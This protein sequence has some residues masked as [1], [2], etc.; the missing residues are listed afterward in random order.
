MRRRLILSHIAVLLVFTIF[1]Y[2]F[3]LRTVYNMICSNLVTVSSQTMTSRCNEINAVLSFGPT[4]ILQ[5]C[6]NEQVQDTLRMHLENSSSKEPCA[7][8]SQET[9]EAIDHDPVLHNYMYNNNVTLSNIPFMVEITYRT[10]QGDYVPIYYSNRQNQTGN[11][12]YPGDDPWIQALLN[13]DG[14]F[15]WDYYSDASNTYLRLSKIIYDTQD[16]TRILGTISLDFSYEHLAMNILTK[17]Y[18]QSGIFAVIADGSTGECIGYRSVALPE[19]L[20]FL[21]TSSSQMP[22]N[23]S[24]YL[25]SRQLSETDFYLIGV[26]S[27][28]EAQQLYYTSCLGFLAAA[29]A[30]LLLGTV[31]SFLLGH[32]ISRPIAHLSRTMKKVQD[33]NLDLSVTTRQHGE[34]G[35]LYDS[36]N[37]MIRMINQLIEENYVSLLNQKQSE[38][39]ALQSQI[40]T[41]FLYNTLDSINWLAKDYHADDISYLVTNLSTLLRTSLNNGKPE[42]SLE[43]E[44][45]HTQSYLNIQQVRFSGLFQVEEDL[46]PS[47]MND[48]VIK[49]LLQP[50]VENAILHS[51]NLP[52]SDPEENRLILRTKN[53]DSELLLEVCNNADPTDLDAIYELLEAEEN[54][55]PKNYGIRSIRRRL[56]IAYNGRASYTY[57]MDACGMLCASIRIP[58]I[59]TMPGRPLHPKTDP[60]SLPGSGQPAD[61]SKRM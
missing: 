21:K 10:N 32:R 34:I 17:L 45:K 36:F 52:D 56:D 33:G 40:N 48:L 8:F 58:R 28:K 59:Y 22:L 29:A 44:L 49:M 24:E 57:T 61:F 14:K 47:A 16:F 26:K 5:L 55:L 53:L 19:D 18:D 50:L 35:E 12:R 7:D 38:L 30:A 54:E 43:Q 39:N 27:L 41:H 15:L 4:Y 23:P 11:K 60:V 13:R 2:T 1:T 3:V 51:F 25:F 37:Y 20:S 31:L 42:L 9:A 46:D 6:I